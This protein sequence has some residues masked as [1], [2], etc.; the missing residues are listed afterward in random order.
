M[1]SQ[2]KRSYDSSR[3]RERAQ[4][5]KEA[6]LDAAQHRFL[7]EGYAATT[8][9]S[10]AADAQ[11]SVETVY[12]AFN[13]KPG[14][15]GAIWKRGLQGSGSS[16]APERSDQMQ[17]T[18]QDPGQ[19]IRNWGRLTTEV[20]PRVAPILLLIRT[21][22]ATDPD[23]MQLLAQTDQQRLQRMRHNARTLVPHL[24]P[25]VTEAAAAEIMWTYSSPDLYDLLVVRRRWSVRRYGQFVSDSMTAAL[26]P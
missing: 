15:V 17:A 12:K 5:T 13:S 14:L 26:L 1:T 18:E 7:T 3:R 19:I 10:V 6:V 24:R 22:A 20:A 2:V 25:G 21:A 8:I 9:A 11:V 23:M 4:R 16:P